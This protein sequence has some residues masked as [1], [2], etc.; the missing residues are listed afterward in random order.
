MCTYRDAVGNLLSD[1]LRRGGLTG[2]GDF[3]IISLVMLV[4]TLPVEKFTWSEWPIRKRFTS[5]A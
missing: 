2:N 5:E 4:E 3:V 1:S